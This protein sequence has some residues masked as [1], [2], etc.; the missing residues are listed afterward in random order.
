VPEA[1]DVEQGGGMEDVRADDLVRTQRKDEQHRQSEERPAAD[2]GQ[3]D[4]EP[5]DKA[6]RDRGDSVAPDH[7]E[8]VVFADH[9]RAH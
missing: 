2:R 8:A 1:G 9:L 5:A 7:V 4:D 3:T 6:D